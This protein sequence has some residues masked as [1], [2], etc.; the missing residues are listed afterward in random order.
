M[1]NYFDAR[2]R[3]RIV[4]T[5]MG[6]VS[7][8]GNTVSEAWRNAVAG[9]SGI[10]P[11]TQFDASQF[12]C[13]IAG[14]VRDFSARDFMDF[15][16]SRRMSRAS[17]LATAAG[18]MALDDAGFGGG[19]PDPERTGVAVGSGVGG[20]EKADANVTMLRS[21]GLSRVSPFALT[22]S[23]ANM[24]SHHI[25][26][27]AGTLGPI[28]TPVAACATGVQ[29]VG[30]GA[31][32]IRSGRA[33]M[34]IT[35]GVEGLI[36][37]A[38]IAGFCA[39]R[40]LATGYNDDP[41]RACRPFDANREG[42]I[43]SEGAGI[44]ILERLDHALARGARIYAEF[45]GHASSSDAYHVAAPDPE[46]KGAIRA[47]RW[48]I[49]DAGLPLDKIDYINAHGTSTPINDATETLAIKQLFGE[50]A[51]EIAISSTKSVMGHAMGGAGALETIFSA[52]TVHDDVM[53]PTINYET[54][55]PDCDLDYVPNHARQ[56]TVNYALCNSFGL[57]GQNACLV[58]GKY[59]PPAVSTNGFH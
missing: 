6:A 18:R 52:M 49:A 7:P 32:F 36:H 33:D 24:P 3:P 37:E 51:Y 47:M 42:F 5:G 17:Q 31:E 54:P 40:A 12:P 13:R 44:I 15:K 28:V 46:G 29:A 39:M 19:I 22:S 45:L 43:L 8:I 16:E 23:L 50:R 55:D 10:G 58:L 4:I 2:G 34:V 57:G 14:E 35:G 56:G 38:A 11:I 30:E 1:D 53:P 9:V 26:V 59:T 41:Q 48:S 20:F 25:S 21:S 27:L